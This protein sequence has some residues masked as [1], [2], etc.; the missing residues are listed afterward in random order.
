LGKAKNHQN[1][2]KEIFGCA[3]VALPFMYLGIPIHFRKLLLKEWK[4]IEDRF[5]KKLA[6]WIGK[7]LSYGDGLIL[8]NS[9]LTS[10]PVFLLSFF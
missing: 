5:E 4:V 1:D 10:L 3:I 8:I 7:I 6:S 2:Y 9:V